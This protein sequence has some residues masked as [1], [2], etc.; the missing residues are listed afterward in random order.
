MPLNT[1][2]TQYQLFYAKKLN[3]I[4]NCLSDFSKINIALKRLLYFHVNLH[5][6]IHN[7]T[8]K[9]LSHHNVEDITVFWL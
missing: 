6:P 2:E 8:F 1:L 4:F 9:P 5:L 7:G 3:L